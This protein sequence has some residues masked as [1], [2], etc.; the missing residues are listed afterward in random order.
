MFREAI[1]AP[2]ATRSASDPFSQTDLRLPELITIM[3]RKVTVLKT[4]VFSQTPKM[5]LR[6]AIAYATTAHVRGFRA[7]MGFSCAT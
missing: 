2:V 3:K 7:I 6:A 4:I 1:P 5:I